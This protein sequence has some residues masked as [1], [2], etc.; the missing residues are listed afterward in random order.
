MH[1]NSVDKNDS[2]EFIITNPKNTI[3]VKNQLGKI[4]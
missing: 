2:I 1:K 4:K 3:R